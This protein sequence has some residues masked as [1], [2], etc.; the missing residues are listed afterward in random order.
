MISSKFELLQK[1]Y[2]KEIRKSCDIYKQQVEKCL[3]EHFDDQY[4]CKPY[5]ESF[6]L[7]I[8]KFN[9]KFLKNQRNL[10]IKKD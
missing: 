4:V 3:I 5:L 1:S 9:S 8:E 10:I 2:D 7:C 6:E